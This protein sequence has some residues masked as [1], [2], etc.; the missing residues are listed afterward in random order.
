MKLL[1]SEQYITALTNISR[2]QCDSCTASNMPFE[3]VNNN[4]SID[5]SARKRIRSH[6]AI[7]KNAGKTILRPSRKGAFVLRAK[8]GTAKVEKAAPDVESEV[9]MP[10][11]ER[12]IGDGLSVLCLPVPVTPGSKGIVQKGMYGHLE[13]EI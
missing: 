11:V 7:G 10:K 3:F 4:A 2:D 5:R 9:V 13:A 12:Q 1:N 6:A 8:P